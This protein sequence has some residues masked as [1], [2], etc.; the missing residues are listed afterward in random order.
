VLNECTTDGLGRSSLRQ[1]LLIRRGNCDPVLVMEARPSTPVPNSFGLCAEYGHLR[2]GISFISSGPA[3]SSGPPSVGVFQGVAV[4]PDG[5]GVVFDVTRQFSQIPALTPEPPDEGIFFV[6]ANGTGL[7]QF[8]GPPSRVPSV[9]GQFRWAASP[10]SRQ[11]AFIDLGP[12]TAGHEAPQVFL[13]DLRSGQRR[14]LTHQPRVAMLEI[15]DPGIWLPT[16]L[17]GR[18]VGFYA[19]STGVGT[20]T[21]FQVKTDGGPEREVPPIT[22]EPGAR[23]VSQFGVTGVHRHA[24]L[25]L[26]PDRPPTNPD[27]PGRFVREVFL[28]DGRQI[29][30]MTKLDRFDTSTGGEGGRGMLVGNRVLFLASA[31]P[32]GTNPDE[33]CQFFSVSTAGE[34]LRQVTQLPSDGERPPQGCIYTPPGCGIFNLSTTVDEATG[35]VLFSSSCDP[36]GANPFGEQIFAMRPDGSGLRQLTDARGMTEDPDGSVHVEVASPFAYQS[37][38]SR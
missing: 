15:G 17:D 12:S 24:V 35:T 25:G 28:V 11:V 27:R 16:F 32:F 8:P 30:Q 19:G 20:L 7:R 3:I 36:V 29:V 6:R 5:S 31:N 10:D 9:I 26:Y 23:I 13:L 37:Q 14:Q 18:T 34:D 33:T 4:L 22:P 2:S 38:K 21:A 1:K